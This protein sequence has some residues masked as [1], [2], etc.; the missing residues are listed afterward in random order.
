MEN[1]VLTIG[2]LI[3]RIS[4]SD[5]FFFGSSLILILLLIYIV[6]LIK[7]DENEIKKEL[8][9]GE[10]PR[11]QPDTNNIASIVNNIEE[12]YDPKPIDLSKYEQ[13]M[14]DTAIISYEELLKR[15]SNDITYDDDY[16]SKSDDL[17]VKKVDD[18]NTSMTKE[19]VNLPTAVM[20]SYENEE[21]F[22]DALKTIQ[23]NL[24]R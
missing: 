4:F 18:S 12:N 3:K 14:E 17:L 21:A 9:N 6:Y 15:S 2:G 24:V 11:M 7:T 19:Y 23:N 16:K 8:G 1:I 22:L 20:M 13:E 10:L 5:I